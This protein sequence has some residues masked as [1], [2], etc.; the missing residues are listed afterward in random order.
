MISQ[1]VPRS[2]SADVVDFWEVQLVPLLDLSP[3]HSIA[4]PVGTTGGRHTRPSAP[5]QSLS[6]AQAVAR[7]PQ[8]ATQ[9]PASQPSFQQQSAPAWHC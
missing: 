6:C 4:L 2:H 5:Q 8:A 9:A 1:P 3:T 7:F